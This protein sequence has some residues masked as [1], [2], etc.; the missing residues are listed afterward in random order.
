MFHIRP[1]SASSFKWF[2]ALTDLSV[3]LPAYSPPHQLQLLPKHLGVL[4]NLRTPASQV[5]DCR[6]K[7][8]RFREGWKWG[9]VNFPNTTCHFNKEN[10]SDHGITIQQLG[11]PTSCH[12]MWDYWIPFPDPTDVDRYGLGKG[13][14]GNLIWDLKEVTVILINSSGVDFRAHFVVVQIQDNLRFQVPWNRPHV[15]LAV[16]SPAFSAGQTYNRPESPSHISA[17]SSAH[18]NDQILRPSAGPM[19]WLIT[20]TLM[21]SVAKGCVQAAAKLCCTWD[22]CNVVPVTSVP[23]CIPGTTRKSHLQHQAQSHTSLKRRHLDLYKLR[24][25]FFITEADGPACANKVIQVYFTTS[26]RSCWCKRTSRT[27][28][29]SASWMTIFFWKKQAGDL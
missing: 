16:P 24:R 18:W 20:T 14:G 21:I 10:E 13:E 11:C 7:T 4:I 5:R 22:S 6:K 9:P 29:V 23:E 19:S 26:C 3:N 15:D 1:R 27:S 17:K 28:S 12:P 25:F 2:K 8:W